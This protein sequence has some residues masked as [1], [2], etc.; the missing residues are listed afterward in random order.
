MYRDKKDI[1][2]S[3]EALCLKAEGAL[4]RYLA[5]IPDAKDR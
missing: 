3:K 4:L 2:I 5:V 1:E